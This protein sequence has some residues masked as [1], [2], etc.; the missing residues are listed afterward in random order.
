[1]NIDK[2]SCIVY[3]VSTSESRCS[4]T[5]SY[6][7]DYFNVSYFELSMTLSYSGLHKDCL[8]RL[9]YFQDLQDL[10]AVF[11]EGWAT[12]TENQLLCFS[13]TFVFAI[14][15][16]KHFCLAV[17]SVYYFSIGIHVKY[18]SFIISE[19][20]ASV[21]VLAILFLQFFWKC[22]PFLFI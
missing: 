22:I 19:C 11:F 20:C 3:I 13:Q 4:R 7:S 16:V 10:F 6:A 17:F 15:V 18:L 1:M 2:Y 5:A 14:F 21:A 12:D 8:A 9:I